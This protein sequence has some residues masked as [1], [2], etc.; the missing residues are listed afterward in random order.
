[1]T[2][3]LDSLY[4]GEPAPRRRWLAVLLTVL[5]PGLGHVYAGAF[6][7]GLLRYLGGFFSGLLF[8]LAWRAFLFQPHLPLAVLALTYVAYVIVLIVEVVGRTGPRTREY[9]LQGFNHPVIYGS[10]LI[11]CHAV[12]TGLL[13]DRI[14]KDV[15]G[16]TE[17]SDGAMFPMLFIG[18]EVLLDRT[19]YRRRPPRRGDL[20]ALRLADRRDLMIRRVIA[21]PRDTVA[22]EG[23]K[24]SVNGIPLEREELGDLSLAGVDNRGEPRGLHLAGWRERNGDRAYVVTH[25][26]DR[27]RATPGPAVLDDGQFFVL[28]DNRDSGPDSRD[29]GP[30]AQERLLG[31]PL[32]VWWS[33]RPERPNLTDWDRIGLAAR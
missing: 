25:R 33:R 29:F 27:E 4:E 20:V 6:A 2:D 23:R 13:A 24:V 30:V 1:M 32:Y 5:M 21:G 31:R 19:A 9:A 28:S 14:G 7:G 15:V 26:P 11:L 10:L 16:K 18:D 12:P 17:V 22:F 3:P 8:L